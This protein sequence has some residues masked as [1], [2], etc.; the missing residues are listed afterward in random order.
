[1]AIYVYRN[2]A[3]GEALEKVYPLGKA[4]RRIRR[5][6][7]HYVRDIAAEHGQ[8]AEVSRG[9]WPK[10][11]TAAGCHPDQIGE[12]EAFDKQHGLKGAEYLPNG[13]VKFFSKRA[14]D[15]WLSGHGLIDRSAYC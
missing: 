12:F 4:P 5:D 10:V 11:S 1:M 15:R 9:L 7:R 8:R 13:D 6:G 2:Q 3:T 14:R